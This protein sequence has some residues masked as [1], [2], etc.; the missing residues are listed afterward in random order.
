MCMAVYGMQDAETAM[1]AVVLALKKCQAPATK[2]PETGR[3]AAQNSFDRLTEHL[4]RLQS[5]RNLN[6]KYVANQNVVN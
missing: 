3:A 5:S 2:A 6:P 1:T 4:Q